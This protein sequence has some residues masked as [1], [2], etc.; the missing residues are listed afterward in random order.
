MTNVSIRRSSGE[1]RFDLMYDDRRGKTKASNVTGGSGGTLDFGAPTSRHHFGKN[2]S[3]NFLEYVRGERWGCQCIFTARVPHH[4]YE[5]QVRHGRR[6]RVRGLA[7]VANTTRVAKTARAAGK[8]PS[9]ATAVMARVTE[10][11]FREIYRVNGRRHLALPL[12]IFPY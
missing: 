10:L 12:Q 11:L 4:P 1:V 6:S 8:A 7:R 9:R 2:N 5:K 3:I